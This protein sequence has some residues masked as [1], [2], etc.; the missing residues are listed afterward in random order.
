MNTFLITES[1]GHKRTETVC[2]IETVEQYI[3]SRF[4]MDPEQLA[5]HNVKVEKVDANKPQDVAPKKAAK[6]DA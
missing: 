2:D 1:S 5:E 3:M 4:G 6:K